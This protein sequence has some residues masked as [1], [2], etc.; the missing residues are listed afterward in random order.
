MLSLIHIYRRSTVPTKNVTAWT[1]TRAAWT[2]TKLSEWLSQGTNKDSGLKSNILFWT[3]EWISAIV[4]WLSYDWPLPVSYTH[5]DVYKRQVFICF[6]TAAITSSSWVDT[7]FT[8]SVFELHLV[9]QYPFRVIF[10]NTKSLRR[11]YLW[12]EQEKK[13]NR[14]PTVPKNVIAWT[15]TWAAWTPTKLSE[16][17]SQGTNT[18][19]GFKSNILFWRCV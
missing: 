10:T 6:S 1:F 17:L 13:V 12:V 3:P 8:A 15:L 19:S 16:W 5:L 18:A 4:V 7:A 9:S 14:H 2:P 11:L